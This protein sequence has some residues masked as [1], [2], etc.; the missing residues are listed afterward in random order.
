M[1]QSFTQET[2]AGIRWSI[3]QCVRNGGLGP[4]GLVA[5]DRCFAALWP[6][7]NLSSHQWNECQ[8]RGMRHRPGQPRS[9]TKQTH[10]YNTK[11][12][13]QREAAVNFSRNYSVYNLNPVTSMSIT[14]K[15]P[16][17]STWYRQPS[18]WAIFNTLMVERQEYNSQRVE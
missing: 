16:G 14:L 9:C 5:G 4:A 12:T 18:L 2:G 6:Q 17:W 3:L 7:F 1:G 11:S 10:A 15:D 13:K 8:W